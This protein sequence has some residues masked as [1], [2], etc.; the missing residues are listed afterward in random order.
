MKIENRKYTLL[1]FIKLP[2]SLSPGAVL[3]LTIHRILNGLMPSFRVL[4]TAGF[5]DTAVK[6][7]NHQAQ[8]SQI[9]IWLIWILTIVVY[10]Y[11][12]FSAANFARVKL[13]VK[14]TEAFRAAIM[15]KRALLEYRYVENSET[16]DLINRVC[17]DPTGKMDNGFYILL[18]LADR[19]VRVCSLLLILITQVWWAALAILAFSYPLF[20]LAIKS[21]KTSYEAKK[22]SDKYLRK[23]QYLQ[24]ILTGRDNFE[25]RSLFAYSDALN[26]RWYDKFLKAYKVNFKAQLRRHVK[27]KGASLITLMISILITGILLSPLYSGLISTGMFMGIVTAVFELVQMMSWELTFITSELA[28]NREYLKDLSAFSGLGEAK[29]ASDL[30]AKNINEPQCI[31]FCGVSFAYPAASGSGKLILNNLSLKLFS[32]KHYAFVG[33]NGAG[34]TTITKLL[35]GLYD[36]YTGDI[37]IDGKNLRKFTQPELK[38]MFSVVYQDFAK[39]KIR[40]ADSIGLGN[41]NGASEQ[42]IKKAVQA[43]GLEEAVLK[44]PEGLDTPLGKIKGNGVDLSG[45][46]WQRVAIARSLVS[47]AP[48]HFLDEP[49]A[50]LDPVAESEVYKLFGKISKGKSTVFITHRLGAA[51]LA[52]EIIVISDGRAAEQ[53]THD[54]L[55]KLDGIYAEMYDAQKGWYI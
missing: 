30:P 8:T 44:L 18:R 55:I 2:F 54:E 38:A 26:I 20:M 9:I 42:D 10:E 40:M 24:G 13:E 5:I 1:D 11:I 17:G 6:I 33:M 36:N 50:A 39:F 12:S 43:I 15:E 48:V 41:A 23:A 19:I 47:N 52:D 34:K 16:W 29:G 37:F 27:M 28:E 53:G 51:R 25:E 35:T 4:A 46:E 49:T 7:T 14:I 31:E 21:G 3:V 22:E 32:K 45:G